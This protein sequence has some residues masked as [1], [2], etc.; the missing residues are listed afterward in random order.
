MAGRFGRAHVEL[1]CD[2][3]MA[4]GQ[5]DSVVGRVDTASRTAMRGMLFCLSC[6]IIMHYTHMYIVYYYM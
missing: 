6:I 4:S 2:S 5:D 1:G 3:S